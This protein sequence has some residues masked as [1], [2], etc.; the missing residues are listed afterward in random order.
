MLTNLQ[1]GP[2]LA[3]K[4][5]LIDLIMDGDGDFFLNSFF[6]TWELSMKKFSFIKFYLA[7]KVLMSTPLLNLDSF[8]N[9]L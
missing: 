2:N 4:C 8:A 6:K 1:N 5:I 9:V 7:R 3:Y